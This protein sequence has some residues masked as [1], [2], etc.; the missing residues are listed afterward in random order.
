M[1]RND[2]QIVYGQVPLLIEPDFALMIE[3]SV[4]T[5]RAWQF[6]ARLRERT[7]TIG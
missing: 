4:P 2:D 1:G 3:K 6:H 7:G 5:T